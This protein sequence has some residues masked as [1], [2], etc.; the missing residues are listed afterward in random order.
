MSYEL[1]EDLLV[2]RGWSPRRYSSHLAALFR[3]TF[4]LVARD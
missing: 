4:L 2:D 1:L 3:S